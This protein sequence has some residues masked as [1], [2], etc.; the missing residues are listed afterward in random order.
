[1]MPS[2]DT[3]L[4]VENTKEMPYLRSCLKEALRIMP[5]T[6]GNLRVCVKDILLSGYRIPAG[7][8]VLM[9]VMA[10]AN[11]ET[12][13]PLHDQFLPERWLKD[14]TGDGR[15]LTESNDLS[16][17]SN[18][19]CK[20]PFVYLPFGFG[21]RTCIGKRVAELVLHTLTARLIRNYQITWLG[22]EELQY[23]SNTITKPCGDIRFRFEKINE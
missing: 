12:Y 5:I 2:T 3:P 23:E 14:T 19:K 22:E 7:T 10:L 20:N 4:T 11:S 16:D 8:S 18:S 13:F 9:G 21:P 1:M 15:T 17:P 6:P